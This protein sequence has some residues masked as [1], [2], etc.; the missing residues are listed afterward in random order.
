MQESLSRIVMHFSW[1]FWTG[2]SKPIPSQDSDL[3]KPAAHTQVILGIRRGGFKV[4]WRT[5]RT[6]RNLQARSR[7]LEWGRLRRASV[8]LGSPPLWPW[9]FFRRTT[10][11]NNINIIIISELRH[12]IR[13][14][15]NR[16]GGERDAE[17]RD[18]LLILL[19]Y[20]E[21]W[22]KRKRK[23][24]SRSAGAEKSSLGKWD[25]NFLSDGKPRE[26]LTDE[27]RQST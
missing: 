27:R 9:G 25:A 6:G 26:Q 16:R 8:C 1:K 18:Q 4:W 19:I 11:E 20:M 13:Q 12:G 22:M 5:W 3:M 24:L 17:N 15:V 2:F 21:V 7:S 23:D 14:T 10:C